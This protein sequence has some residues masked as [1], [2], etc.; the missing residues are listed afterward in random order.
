MAAEH[1]GTGACGGKKDPFVVK[2]SIAAVLQLSMC[3]TPFLFVQI[4]GAADFSTA[5]FTPFGHHSHD[6]HTVLLACPAKVRS[7][8]CHNDVWYKLIPDHAK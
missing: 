6:L 1:G 7:W 2:C 4:Q 8:L 3:N 5:D